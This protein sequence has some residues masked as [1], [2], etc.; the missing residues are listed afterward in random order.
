MQF[1]Q[2]IDQMPGFGALIADITLDDVACT[3]ELRQSTGDIDDLAKLNRQYAENGY[4]FFKNILPQAAI[5]EARERMIAPLLKRGLARKVGAQ[6]EWVGGEQP[7]LGQEAP[8]FRG[9]I[10][11][12]FAA[13][14]V[15][16]VLRKLLGEEPSLV[17]IVQYRAF[18]PFGP[19]GAVHQDGYYSPGIEGFRPLWIPLVEMD[20]DMGGL[21]LAA[22][23]TGRGYLH[24]T[25]K[26]PMAPIPRDQIPHDAW[27]RANY[28]PGDVLV[29]HPQTPHVGLVNRSRFVRL[30]IDTRIQSA[31]NPSVLTGRVVACSPDSV[32]LS[33]AGGIEKSFVIT[34]ESFLRTTAFAGQRVTRAE[35]ADVTP[36]GL[37]VVAS[38]S[39]NDTIMMLRRLSAG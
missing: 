18:R 2:R 20:D 31:T 10:Q 38:V 6:A 30:S 11:G 5:V 4:L 16:P 8:E 3:S 17:P 39:P 33:L 29:I 19:V 26:M 32:V 23:M 15:K 28:Q 7:S 27:A 21:A 14:G 36:V 22:G 24:N 9:V 12:L 35:F 13:E 37:E 1:G 25:D 34:D